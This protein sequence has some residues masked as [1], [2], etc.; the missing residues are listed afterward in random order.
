M[1]TIHRSK[2]NY[3]SSS[4]SIFETEAELDVEY[5]FNSD[6][7]VCFVNMCYKYGQISNSVQFRNKV[8]PPDGGVIFLES[9][10]FYN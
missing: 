8:G 1:Q 4:S 3:N 7:A 6:S 9:Y 2:A 5:I 10:Y